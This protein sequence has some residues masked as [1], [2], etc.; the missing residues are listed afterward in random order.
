MSKAMCSLI[1]ADHDF[2][3]VAADGYSWGWLSNWLLH[4][5]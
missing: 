1:F 5:R 2:D 3:I 4:H